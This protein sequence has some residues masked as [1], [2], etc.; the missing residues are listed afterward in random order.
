MKEELLQQY[1][2]S[3]MWMIKDLTWRFDLD[4]SCCGKKNEGGYSP[5]LTKAIAL[6]KELEEY[7]NG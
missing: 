2:E 1:L 3:L 6:K 5:K 4:K 7:L